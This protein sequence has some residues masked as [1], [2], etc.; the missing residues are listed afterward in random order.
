[1]EQVEDHQQEDEQEQEQQP[2][3]NNDN[4]D[5]NG[6]NN[7][8]NNNGEEQEQQLIEEEG[9]IHL[10]QTKY[11]F[12][13]LSSF[14]TTN[15][16]VI[17]DQLNIYSTPLF[18]IITT[19]NINEEQDQLL[20]NP[21]YKDHPLFNKTGLTVSRKMKDFEWLYENL[22]IDCIGCLI[23]PKDL[24]TTN[25]D[26]L[27]EQTSTDPKILKGKYLSLF[28]SFCA[29]HPILCKSYLFWD[30]ISGSEE[31]FNNTMKTQYSIID[32]NLLNNLNNN[33]T[34]N[35]TNEK[36]NSSSSGSSSSG[37][38]IKKENMLIKY[39]NN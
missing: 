9:S 7:G 19:V 17:Y 28:L 27:Y 38:M 14:T 35:N 34:N 39:Q 10:S 24:L 11:P 12:V 26:K 13:E 1:E 2:L 20:D 32:P 21:I 25:I 4:N 31:E 5:G 23:P 16:E 15:I 22:K 18:T 29:R 30:F 33:T 3:D 8:N 6:N 36:S 37:V